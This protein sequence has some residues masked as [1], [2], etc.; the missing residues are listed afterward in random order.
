MEMP[1]PALALTQ[2]MLWVVVGLTGQVLFILRFVAQWVASERAGRSVI[3]IGFWVF[4]IGGAGIVLAYA[5]YRRDP[6]FI[7]G[8]VMMFA[9]YVRN[10]I[11]I[12]RSKRRAMEY[13]K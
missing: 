4:G 9:T 7:L 1:Y 13:D 5:I 3:P 6:V 2:D 8:Q 10:F 11:H 12:T